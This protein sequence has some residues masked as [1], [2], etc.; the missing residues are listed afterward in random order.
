MAISY[1][2][3]MDATNNYWLR[4]EFIFS[5]PGV[6]CQAGHNHVSRWI[7][8]KTNADVL[9]PDSAHMLLDWRVWDPR[10]NQW[11]YVYESVYVPGP[12]TFSSP[13]GR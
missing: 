7:L 10:I 5:P 13:P 4:F 1:P 12:A 2:S 9:I 8:I 6:F 11:S 3:A